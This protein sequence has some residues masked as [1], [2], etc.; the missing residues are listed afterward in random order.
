[1]PVVNSSNNPAGMGFLSDSSFIPL[2]PHYLQHHQSSSPAESREPSVVS[3]LTTSA[4][5]SPRPSLSYPANSINNNNNNNNTNGHS[6][7]SKSGMSNRSGSTPPTPLGHTPS[8]PHVRARTISSTSTSTIRYQIATS[9]LQPS[10]PP[11][12]D[13]C[14]PALRSP[15]TPI[16]SLGEPALSAIALASPSPVAAATGAAVSMFTGAISTTTATAES[17]TTDDV[18]LQATRDTSEAPL[19]AKSNQVLISK[20]LKLSNGFKSAIRTLCEQQ[21]EKVLR[22]DDDMILELLTK[23]EQEA[24]K[25]NDIDD[26]EHDGDA[27]HVRP[28][29]SSSTSLVT[30]GTTNALERYQITVGRVWEE[31][32][33]ILMSIGR[34]RDLVQFGKVHT[35]ND[36]DSDDSEED[37]VTKEAAIR[38]TLYST[39]LHHANTLVTVLGEFLEC[40]STIQRHVG[41]IKSHRKS[42]EYKRDEDQHRTYPLSGDESYSVSQ[43][44]NFSPTGQMKPTT[45]LSATATSMSEFI[46]DEPRPIKVLDRALARKLKRK[47]K[48]RTITEKVRRSFSDFKKRSTSSLLTIFPP[49]GDGNNDGFLD[50]FS[51]DDYESD[52]MGGDISSRGLG[53][54]MT[55]S[56][57]D[58]DDYRFSRP[59]SPLSPPG[60]P[61]TKSDYL[62]HHQPAQPT[63]R[64]RRLSS[65]DSSG[66]PEQWW[67][68]SV[69]LN[70]TDDG[71]SPTKMTM[72]TPGIPLASSPPA[73]SHDIAMSRSMS[74]DRTLDS[75]NARFDLGSPAATTPPR[76][77][78]D[79]L[80]ESHGAS[81][82]ALRSSYGSLNGYVPPMSSM[83]SEG[84]EKRQSLLFRR[85]S[86][87]QSG[88]TANSI[89]APLPNTSR[90]FSVH[91]ATSA[92]SSSPS[93]HK[94]RAKPPKPPVALPTL[95]PSPTQSNVPSVCEEASPASSSSVSSTTSSVPRA[96]NRTSMYLAARS[97]SPSSQTPLVLDSPFTRQTS[98]RIAHDRNRYSIKM[99]ADELTDFSDIVPSTQRPK[100]PA[101]TPSFSSSPTAFWR[102]RSYNDALEKSWSELK[103]ESIVSTS[104]GTGSLSG[105]HS[106]SS[107]QQATP[108]TAEFNMGSRKSVHGSNTPSRSS[109][110]RLT[111]F[112]FFVPFFSKN[113]SSS[114]NSGSS[115]SS[116]RSEGTHGSSKKGVN[117]RRNSMIRR[118]PLSTTDTD[119][120]TRRHSSPLILSQFE[121]L[122]SEEKVSGG[123]GSGSRSSGRRLSTASQQSSSMSSSSNRTSM[124]MMPTVSEYVH[125]KEQQKQQ[126]QYYE[127]SSNRSDAMTTPVNTG[128]ESFAEMAP[129]PRPSQ[130]SQYPQ[131]HSQGDSQV[132]L[133]RQIQVPGAVVGRI[134]ED[135][136]Y[137]SDQPATGLATQQTPKPQARMGDMRKAWELLNLDVKRLNPYSHLRAYATPYTP[138]SNLWALS[139]PNA[140]QSTTSPRVLHLCENGADAL[141]L[142]MVAGKL[143]IVAGQLENLIERLADKNPQDTEYV[144]NFLLSH[145]FFIDSEDFLERLI[146]R[147]NIQPQHGAMLYFEK[148][149]KVIQ[150][151]VLCVIQRWIQI[152]YEDFELNSNLLKTLKRFLETDVRQ[153]GFAMEGE[154]IEKNISI[155][156]SGL[157]SPTGPSSRFEGI[158]SIPSNGSHPSLEQMIEFGPTPELE[159]TS[160]ILQL[161]ARDLA[162]YLTL[163]DMKAFRSITVFELMSGWWKRRQAQELKK[164]NQGGG[165]DGDLGVNSNAL[166]TDLVMVDVDGVEAGAIEAFTRRANML[167]YWVAHEIVSTAGVKTRKQLLKKFIEVARICRSL[168][169][170][171]TAMFILSALGSTPVR[172]L[173]A[174]WKLVSAKD[175]ETLSELEELLD[176][177]GNMRCYR[178]AISEVTAPAIPFLP[179]LL[180]DITFILDGNPTWIES[181]VTPKSSPNGSSTRSSHHET[182]SSVTSTATTGS[183]ST[184]DAEPS[185]D[186]V[187]LVN[188]DKFRQLTR[189]VEN[190]VDMARSADYSFEHQLLRQARVFRP[191]SPTLSGANEHDQPSAHSSNSNNYYGSSVPMARRGSQPETSGVRGALD[192]ISEL[193]ERRLVK[194]S[195]LY[196]VQQRVVE[197]EFSTRPKASN[198]LWKSGGTTAGG[199]GGGSST[200]NGSNGINSSGHIPYGG[201]AETVIRTVQ[202]EEDYLMGLSLMC[203][204]SR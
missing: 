201:P 108:V 20:L 126:Q 32:E 141:V 5:S 55:E 198:S 63:Q 173:H 43:R 16:A 71:F 98:I 148:W 86:S 174:S 154:F 95:P 54:E 1:M 182:N 89:S 186:T 137:G 152:Q 45:P 179:I 181:K 139:H 48:F 144:S 77:S 33:I 159:P 29:N 8:Q 183:S 90:P 160:P 123:N 125:A 150:V 117:K 121:K 128:S 145:S 100:F 199:Q 178:Q 161:N 197:V 107:S 196:G 192:H 190:A 79:S 7:L 26:T 109:S 166:P 22:F 34:I 119:K 59:F 142:E 12:T 151:K 27:G 133:Q 13:L 50:S 19:L 60:S 158:P 114:V 101:R 164:Q 146:A 39:L 124:L 132:S 51:D 69:K 82:T 73:Y 17:A 191:S 75:I 23:W 74:S 118:R 94:Y 140:K 169:N 147:F 175:M 92:A 110:I 10:E 180:K 41:V 194:A 2:R 70:V 156:R 42:A 193:V 163:A 165:V 40:V 131:T 153:S 96:S 112:D 72:A 61:G 84:S 136:P 87:V 52:Y 155:K 76:H 66:L 185:S 6:A 14:Q 97:I 83:K 36:F 68:G 177:T 168:N 49:L 130:T 171:H 102:R 30:M 88:L 78:L 35:Y 157:S 104:S 9:I 18:T 167:S 99:P 24:V 120:A 38:E 188:F 44:A 172:R 138:Q 85:R 31:T 25:E 170:L 28:D 3:S 122:L 105:Q 21:N 184:S 15:P 58:D 203:E 91:T 162:R 57:Y 111:S 47:T 127:S 103:H 46:S 80:R 176:I 200:L 116:N 4:P 195:G 106:Q 129:L 143:Q 81:A 189:Y 65:K 62:K 204:P 11:L 115:G 37:A 135:E 134:N 53:T 149:Q 113:S 56:V 64:H 187:Q 202:G 93:K 67:P